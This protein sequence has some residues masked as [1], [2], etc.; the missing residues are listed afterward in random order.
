MNYLI[1]HP[2]ILNLTNAARII[3]EKRHTSV[4]TIELEM[5]E[6]ELTIQIRHRNEIMEEIRALKNQKNSQTDVSI[7]TEISNRIAELNRIQGEIQ[8][9]I[10]KIHHLRQFIA[11]N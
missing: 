1:V 4:E 11:K 9:A 2:L 5:I 8:A 10:S 6:N 3:L 7:V